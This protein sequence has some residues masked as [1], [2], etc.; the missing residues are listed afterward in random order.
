MT[1]QAQDEIS[2]DNPTQVAGDNVL[3][4]M[5]TRHRVAA[6]QDRAMF[7]SGLRVA[8]GRMAAECPGLDCVVQNVVIREGAL[9]EVLELIETGAFLALLEGQG[10]RMGLLM[11]CPMVMSAMIEAQTTGRVD[12]TPPLIRKPT[13]TDAALIAPM[14]DAFLRRAEQRCAELPQ[15]AL[16][17]GHAYGSY[18]DDPRPLGLMLEDGVF[19]I[20][21]LRVSLGFGAK[22]GDW[23]VVLPDPVQ[24]TPSQTDAQT[25]AEADRDWQERLTVAVGH[26]EVLVHAMLGRIHIT[27]TEALRLRPGDILRLPD[28]ALESL[29]L[30]SITHAPLGVGRLGQARGQRAVRLTADPGVLS[31]AM[32]AVAAPLALPAQIIPF[33]PPKAAFVPDAPS[34]PQPADGSAQPEAQE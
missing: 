32:G 26:S 3:V 27:L 12:P 19:H 13:R 24:D 29:T 33:A 17:S 10:D 25:E 16:M 6:A 30:E 4:A 15:A 5:A 22:E 21:H 11:A 7:A 31:D 9:A 18:L 34:E 23:I 1:Q 28:S 8:F 2:S 14:I 20:L